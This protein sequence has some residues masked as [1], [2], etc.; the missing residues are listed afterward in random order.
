MTQ[1]RDLTPLIAEAEL[2]WMLSKT[3]C[4]D[5]QAFH[6]TRGYLRAV[7]FRN[8]AAL[9]QTTL[10]D[11]I[12][13][14]TKQGSKILI[15]GSAD[16]GLF[17]VV[18]QATEGQNSSITVVDKCPTPLYQVTA[19][20]DSMGREVETKVADLTETVPQ[21]PFD[22]IFMHHLLPFIRDELQV[23]LLSDLAKTL[24]PGGKL[25]LV[26]HVRPIEATEKPRSEV[27][28]WTKSILTLMDVNSISVPQEEDLFLSLLMQTGQRNN[29]ASSEATVVPV[30]HV[31]REAGFSIIRQWHTEAA[32]F[33]ALNG[34]GGSATKRSDYFLAERLAT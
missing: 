9:D 23:K 34:G 27:D 11:V 8:G 25:F 20:A 7:G 5:C 21:G 14:E 30:E 32:R 13:D 1:P 22:F 28:N 26:N 3:H 24:N 12:R 18:A 16:S 2:G 6:A 33:A 29:H 31:L 10:I 4:R 15:A 17:N 19:L